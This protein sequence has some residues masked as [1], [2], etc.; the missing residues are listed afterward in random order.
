MK[1][2]PKKFD[3]ASDRHKRQLLSAI[4]LIAI[5]IECLTAWKPAQ[6]ADTCFS[7][8]KV[9]QIHPLHGGPDTINVFAVKKLPKR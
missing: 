3:T 7:A 8:S 4:F 9:Y 2:L 6:A 5:G 1:I